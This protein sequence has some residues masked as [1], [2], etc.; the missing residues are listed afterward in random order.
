MGK[1][2]ELNLK[3]LVEEAETVSRAAALAL[4]SPE[5]R[6]GMF[7]VLKE[8]ANELIEGPKKEEAPDP[9]REAALSEAKKV[10][11][12]PETK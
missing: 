11:A 10:A 1:P 9:E 8:K 7:V 5:Q 12:N 3:M 6:A 4:I 2:K